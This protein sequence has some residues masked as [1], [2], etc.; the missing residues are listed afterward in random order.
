[1]AS[2]PEVRVNAVAAGLMLTEWSQ[3]FTEEKL[4]KVRERNVLKKITDVEDVAL[5][6]VSLIENGSMTVSTIG[7]RGGE[8]YS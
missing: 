1:M 8:R 3:G 4:K 6:Y 2:A 5:Q 7:E